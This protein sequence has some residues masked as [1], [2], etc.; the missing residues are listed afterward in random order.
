MNTKIRGDISVGDKSFGGDK[1]AESPS[2]SERS[3]TTGE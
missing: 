1:G 3:E 2:E